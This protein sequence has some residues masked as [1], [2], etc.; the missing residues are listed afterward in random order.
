VPA[1]QRRRLHTERRPQGP[2]QH[3]AERGKE[4]PINRLKARTPDLTLQ[5]PQLMAQNENFDLLR[6]LRPQAQDEQLEQAPQ[7]PVDQR[8]HDP[9]RTPH[10]DG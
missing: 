1:Q 8:E 7:R 5:H 10:L 3:A 2:R 6:L 9:Q 4:N